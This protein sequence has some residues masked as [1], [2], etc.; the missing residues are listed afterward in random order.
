MKVPTLEYLKA[1]T[2]RLIQIKHSIAKLC[3]DLD[4]PCCDPDVKIS[5]RNGKPN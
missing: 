1:L 5:I 2:E 3:A 4:C